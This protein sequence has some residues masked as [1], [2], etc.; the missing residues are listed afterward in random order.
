MQML[1]TKCLKLVRT[2]F[3]SHHC[4]TVEPSLHA[5]DSNFEFHFFIE[6][7][8]RF[9]NGDERFTATAPALTFTPPCMPH[10]IR[11]TSASK[12][13]RF[14]FLC[15]EIDPSLSKA[16]MKMHSAFRRF[17]YLKMGMDLAPRIE[18]LVVKHQSPNQILKQSA[19]HDFMSFLYEVMSLLEAPRRTDAN[20]YARKLISRMRRDINSTFDLGAA[21]AGLGLSKAHLVRVFKKSTGLPPQRYFNRLKMDTAR[22]LLKRTDMSL[23]R[24]AE[25]LSFCD[26]FYFSRVFKKYTGVSPHHFRKLNALEPVAQTFHPTADSP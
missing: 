4:V 9:H 24:I 2:G 20:L 26:E 10:G 17:G 25:Q 7:S 21:A 3:V 12:Q 11:N 5:H 15:F 18:Q 14:F 19:Q 8:C 22:D 23:A 13:L 6:G 16:M 1:N